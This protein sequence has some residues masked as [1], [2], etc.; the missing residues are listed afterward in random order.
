MANNSIQEIILV[1]RDSTCNFIV[2]DPSV[3]RNHAQIINYGDCVSV[4][5]LG[6]VNGTYVNRTRVTTETALHPG[7]ELRVGN[8]SVP[9]EQLV[10]PSKQGG[11][12]GWI[13]ILIVG[14]ALLL[15][16]LGVGAYFLW[17][18]KD[19]D[20]VMKS[21]KDLY[22]EVIDGAIQNDS[23]K[24]EN[25]QKDQQIKEKSDENANLTNAKS[26]LEKEKSDLV[27]QKSSLEEQNSH[28]KNEKTK[29][30]KQLEDSVAYYKQKI[31]EEQKRME[32][33]I[34]KLNVKRTFFIFNTI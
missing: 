30:S 3:S 32:D 10:T 22:E 21:N 16:G 34:N 20:D 2:N 25:A 11:K 31:K 1:G 29:L 12:K 18:H 19:L 4:V 6:S 7:D 24:N 15:A 17:M 27:N 9:W 28:L 8:A 14:I 5:D 23:L 13:W 26:N 33:S